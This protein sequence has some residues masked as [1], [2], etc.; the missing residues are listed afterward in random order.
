MYFILDLSVDKNFKL[1]DQ[2]FQLDCE[3]EQV[4]LFSLCSHWSG[5]TCFYICV[6]YLH[7][8]S[9]MYHVSTH[10]YQV[11]TRFHVCIHMCLMCIYTR[12]HGLH[13]LSTLV[14]VMCRCTCKHIRCIWWCDSHV[15]CEYI[16]MY[17]TMIVMNV[18]TVHIYIVSTLAWHI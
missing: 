8:Y 13:Y 15:N 14:Y 3:T 10:A 4:S 7:V 12:S 17:I 18:L 9:Y 11:F 6:T 5:Y 1:V 2:H 16:Y